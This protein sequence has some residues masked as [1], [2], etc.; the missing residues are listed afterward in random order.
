ME[1]RKVADMFLLVCAVGIVS[2]SVAEEP[3]KILGSCDSAVCY[4]LFAFREM[5]FDTR[6]G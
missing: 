5:L 1:R 3:F 6:L 4:V 2:R